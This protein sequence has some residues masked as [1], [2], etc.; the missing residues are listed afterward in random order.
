MENL[1]TPNDL[2]DLALK[3]A[4]G[5]K[6]EREAIDSIKQSVDLQLHAL[7]TQN[8][9]Q[10]E[11]TT[12]QTSLQV[13][14]LQKLRNDREQ[15]V[16]E[17]ADLLNVPEERTRLNMLVIALASELTDKELKTELA[18][19]AA[20]L[21]EEAAAAK[22][23]CKELAYSLQYALHLGQSMIEAIHGTTVP[24]PVQVYTAKGNKELSS[25]H[26]MMV[27]EIG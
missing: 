14:T 27:N 24:A 23:S 19:L 18:A 22:D 4:D 25:N 26:R 6:K 13:N 5:L 16:V 7:R 20:E 10:V 8:R 12:L 3:L 15:I 2:H 1:E 17:M 21:P 9:E 11:E